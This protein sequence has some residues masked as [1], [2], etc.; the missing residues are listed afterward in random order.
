MASL[1]IWPHRKGRKARHCFAKSQAKS[2]E[3][4][5]PD[6][7]PYVMQEKLGQAVAAGGMSLGGNGMIVLT[8]HLNGIFVI[9]NQY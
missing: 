3:T 4:F 6:T 1:V 5:G 9:I 7:M 8:I 2:R